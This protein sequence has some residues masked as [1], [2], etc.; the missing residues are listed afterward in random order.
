MEFGWVGG[1]EE[2]WKA[3][4]ERLRFLGLVDWFFGIFGMS[5]LLC[6]I[7]IGLRWVAEN[8]L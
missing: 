6:S 8:V 4:L 1:I 5:A 3:F 7:L 2:M